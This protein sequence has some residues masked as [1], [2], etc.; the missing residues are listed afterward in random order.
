[1]KVSIKWIKELLPS[2]EATADEIAHRVGQSG[3]EIEARE[4]LGAKLANVV[5]GEV[6]DLVLHPDAEKLRVAQ[7]FDGEATRPVVCGA[8][9]VAAGQKVA[10]AKLGASL[11]NGMTI[12]RRKVRGV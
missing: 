10:L 7:V 9:N 2:L 8:P 5:V 1:M 11:P 6:T 12:E 3:F 4:D